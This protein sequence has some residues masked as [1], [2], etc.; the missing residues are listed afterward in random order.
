MDV[1]TIIVIVSSIVLPLII[2]GVSNWI[3][4]QRNKSDFKKMEATFKQEKQTKTFENINKAMNVWFGLI[5]NSGDITGH[6]KSV[7]FEPEYQAYMEN[8]KKA[9]EF[10][11]R[12]TMIYGDEKVV[13]TLA[14]Y[15][16]YNFGGVENHYEAIAIYSILTAFLKEQVTG[17][18]ILPRYLLKIQISDYEQNANELDRIIN[19]KTKAIYS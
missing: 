5:K 12:Q 14:V 17:E 1:N 6:I 18:Q 9:M 8:D 19:E 4:Y 15:Q 7:Y 13:R 2:S 10:L 11:L 16:E 3:N